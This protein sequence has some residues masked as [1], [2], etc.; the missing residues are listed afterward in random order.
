MQIATRLSLAFLAVALAAT[1]SLGGLSYVAGRNALIQQTHAQLQAIA[2]I[3]QQRLEALLAQS[4]ERLLL[5][6]SRTQLRLSLERFLETPNPAD[7]ALMNRILRDARAQIDDFTKISIHTA[8]GR[9]VASTD[10][11]EPGRQAPPDTAPEGGTERIRVDRFFTYP[12][13]ELGIR[14]SATL[15]LND[16][17]L[18]LLVI[19]ATGQKLLD[20]IQD[21]TGLGATGETLLIGRS[22]SGDALFLTPARFAPD[23][24]LK[25]SL[26]MGELASPA[27]QSLR[28]T[29]PQMFS[30]TDY[31]GR[32]VLAAVRQIPQYGWGLLTKIDQAEVLAPVDRLVELLIYLIIAI[33][34]LVVLA[35]WYIARSISRPIIA[36]TR[37]AQAVTEGELTC[38]ADSA[39]GDEIG[40]L[41]RSFNA[42]TEKLISSNAALKNHVAEL[43]RYEQIV[44]TSGDM[45]AFVDQEQRY[46]LANPAY[47][48]PFNT[49]P[50]GLRLRHVEEVV[51]PLAY[52][53]IAP[54][55]DRALAGEAQYFVLEPRFPDGLT[56]MLSAEFLPYRRQEEVLGAVI[57]LRNITRQRQA[58]ETLRRSEAELRQAQQL[59]GVGNWSWDLVNDIHSW[60]DEIYRIYGRDPALPAAVYPEVREYFTEESWERLTVAVEQGLKE[61]TPYLCDAEVIRP[62]GNHRWIVARGEATRDAQGKVISLRGTVQD[63]TERK[64]AEQEI[65][66]LNADLE[67]RV[68]ERTAELSAANRELDAFAYAVSHDL[69]APLRAMSGFSQALAED[70]G[71]Q[72]QEEARGYLRQIELA[73]QRMGKLID[74]LLALSRINRGPL[75]CERV[76]LSDLAQR[77]LE[78]LAQSDP[79]RQVSVSIEAGLRVDGDLSMIEIVMHN[80][81]GNAWKYTARTTN[82]HIRVYSEGQAD[83]RRFCIADNGAGFDMGHATR[84]FSPFQRLHRQE[85]FPGIGIGLATVQRIINRHGGQIEGRGETGKGA[86]FRF[87]LPDTIVDSTIVAT[88]TSDK[89]RFN[90]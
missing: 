2:A 75:K 46:L 31:R 15:S 32:S 70:F 14:L 38:R 21:Y 33:T 84:L 87:S 62:D 64:L 67:R 24:A 49:T 68:A 43:Q 85:E 35:S 26:P 58:E 52:R 41:A 44:S 27:V 78:E 23:T 53:E 39:G 7:Q 13:G 20:L 65:R 90:E 89:E 81:L 74:A 29:A 54:H 86:L 8:D 76:D 6:A 3:Q 40:A 34:A 88:T 69:R 25:R 36:L 79:Q 28:L 17:V 77:L 45:L 11:R 51:G 30:G 19:E 10:R 22:G 66:R 59:A 42:M 5:V 18:G 47:A 73:S 56:R 48:E 37:T 16:R 1:L 82:P 71:D 50:A 55:M 12:G 63:I 72:L 80:L 57:N 83:D 4:R 61:G 9:I 60:S